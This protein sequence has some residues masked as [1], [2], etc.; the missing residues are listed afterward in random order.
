MQNGLKF[1]VGSGELVAHLSGEIDHH[2]AKGVREEIDARLFAARPGVLILD[3][4]AVRF[5]DSSGIA[6]IMGRAEISGEMG[7]RVKITGLSRGLLKLVMLSGI[8]KIKNL[9]IE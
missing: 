7:C 6:L 5:M 3:F 8:P 1:S 2:V 9:T 4:S